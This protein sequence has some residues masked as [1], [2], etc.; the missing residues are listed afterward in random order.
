[1]NT[2]KIKRGVVQALILTAVSFQGY[3]AGHPCSQN[4]L[5]ENDLTYFTATLQNGILDAYAYARQ[6]FSSIA[7]ATHKKVDFF[8]DADRNIN[9][10]DARPGAIRG[11]DFRISCIADFPTCTMYR[12]PTNPYGQ[13]I[14]TSNQVQAALF[15]GN[16]GLQVRV[17]INYSAADI[18]AMAHGGIRFNSNGAGNG[19]RCPETGV[20]DTA[21]GSAKVR[22]PALPVN[23]TVSDPTGSRLTSWR[24]QTIGDQFR[25]Q[26][27]YRN[28]I[29]VSDMGFQGRLELD[30][31]RSL[32]TGLV[33]TPF[34][35]NSPFN[36]IPTWGWDVAI[37]FQGGSGSASD[38]TP[39]Y[40]DFGKQSNLIQP[41][42]SYAYPYGF[43]FGESY[44]DG[45]WRILSGNQ[46][47]LEGSLS[48]LDARYWRLPGNGVVSVVRQ[49]TKGQ[50]IGRL[51]T[52]LNT[53]I[54]DMIPKNKRAFD[55]ATKLSIPGITWIPAQMI[56]KVDPAGDSG[57][58]QWDLIKIDT[59]VAKKNLVIR[60]TLSRLEPSWFLWGGVILLDTDANSSTGTPVN[61]PP[62]G[63]T[64]GADYQIAIYTIDLG[65]YFGR[66][67]Y[68][69]KPGGFKE[70]HDSWINF[71]YSNPNQVNS[72]A[73]FIT[74]IPLASIGNPKGKVRLYIGTFG[75]RLADI[76]PPQ[77]LVIDLAQVK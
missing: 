73:A 30:T 41:P 67:A 7:I 3:T 60:G 20:F 57:A 52:N 12:L 9:T 1:M 24:F 29:R 6:P 31:D 71:K 17:S 18:F 75:D 65:G 50:I 68:L 14:K 48:M 28:A 44:N 58:Q 26:V 56:S 40:L 69:V 23:A 15:Y 21:T 59:E 55:T 27:G 47:V 66:T 49:P 19:D 37:Q 46:L 8:I 25:I 51:F 4:L 54:T 39:F 38:P 72:S 45:R 5:V 11:T 2:L 70:G 22:Q 13:E 74:T 62:G 43:P 34:L 35:I 32:Q 76:G 10:G 16:R 63:T 61:N 77:P 64:I 36:E 42:R 33:Q 53:Q